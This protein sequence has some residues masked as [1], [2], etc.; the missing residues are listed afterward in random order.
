MSLA[1][2][3]DVVFFKARLADGN[4]TV[5]C[6]ADLRADTVRIGDWRISGSMR[7]SDTSAGDIRRAPG[8]A[9]PI[10]ARGGR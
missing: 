3:A 9:R 8:A 7:L 10:R 4:G 6:A 2:V 5:L 1:S